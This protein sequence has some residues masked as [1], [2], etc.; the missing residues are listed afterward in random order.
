M[1]A[2]VLSLFTA[3][4][5]SAIAIAAPYQNS[6]PI[7]HNTSC[8]APSTVYVTIPASVSTVFVTRPEYS[9]LPTTTITTVQTLHSTRTLTRSLSLVSSSSATAK[10]VDHPSYGTIVTQV[11]VVTI[12]EV[13]S[14]PTSISVANGASSSDA[15]QF[16]VQ[17]SKTIWV[18]ATPSTVPIDAVFVTSAVTVVPVDTPVTDTH[19]TR[20]STLHISTTIHRTSTGTHTRTLTTSSVT[21]SVIQSTGTVF[22]GI[23]SGGWNSTASSIVYG[24]VTGPT[25]S[26]SV[27]HAHT[28]LTLP[29]NFSTDVPSVD[30]YGPPSTSISLSSL[31]AA[32]GFQSYPGHTANATS[33]VLPT[34]TSDTATLNSSTT[35][36]K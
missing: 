33:I 26:S 30:I 23:G 32:S 1:R 36:R 34:G 15:Y 11:S 21:I 28:S 14:P 19:M 12:T 31:A 3:L 13:Y 29:S 4:G 9:V 24:A 17:S 7:F 22:T 18:G 10:G 6:S 5:L 20:T 16:Y 27:L 8:A 35:A 2:S 25:G